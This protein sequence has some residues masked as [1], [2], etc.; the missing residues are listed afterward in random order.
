MVLLNFSKSFRKKSNS[1]FDDK[2]SSRELG[3]KSKKIQVISINFVLKDFSPLNDVWNHGVE[4]E[5][6]GL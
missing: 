5:M 6:T 2:A 1:Y 3:F 4:R